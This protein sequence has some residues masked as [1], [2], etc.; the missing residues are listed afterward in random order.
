MLATVSAR[1]KCSHQSSPY[2]EHCEHLK[3][4]THTNYTHAQAH[5]RTH[6]DFA[7]PLLAALAMLAKH[8]RAA[9]PGCRGGYPPGGD[10]KY[11]RPIPSVPHGGL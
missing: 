11:P 5:A 10:R 4:L 3:H 9:T 7:K 2:G 1:M 6:R 8:T